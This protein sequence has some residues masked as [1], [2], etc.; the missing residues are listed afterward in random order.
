ML[1]NSIFYFSSPPLRSC[2]YDMLK[3]R[4]MSGSG[5]RETKGRFLWPLTLET[6]EGGGA[7]HVGRNVGAARESTLWQRDRVSEGDLEML[8]FAM[9]NA[10]NLTNEDLHSS[11][12][13]GNQS[14][15]FSPLR[16]TLKEKS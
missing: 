2:Q 6:G 12:G 4:K 9:S 15:N 7:S 3:E 1:R 5:S 8:G 10:R 16:E 11:S 14:C 13:C